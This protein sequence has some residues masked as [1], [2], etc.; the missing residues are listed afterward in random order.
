VQTILIVDKSAVVRG[1]VRTIV[2]GARF[3]VVETS[4]YEA[5]Y[6]LAQ[7]SV[8]AIVMDCTGENGH[9]LAT[10]KRLRASVSRAPTP[11]AAKCELNQCGTVL[12][13]WADAM[14]VK[15][16]RPAQLLPKLEAVLHARRKHQNLPLATP[17]PTFASLCY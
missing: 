1:L 15:R 10:L 16:F 13:Q 17:Q 11:V 8:D 3:R 6:Q 7:G 9:G 12:G 2:E 5:G 14:L 4:S